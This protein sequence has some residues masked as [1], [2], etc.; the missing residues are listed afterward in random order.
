MVVNPS[1]SSLHVNIAA[2][3]WISRRSCRRFWV[4][5]VLLWDARCFWSVE[6]SSL[7]SEAVPCPPLS[8]GER[9]KQHNYNYDFPHSLYSSSTTSTETEEEQE[10]DIS[11]FDIDESHDSDWIENE[12]SLDSKSLWSSASDDHDDSVHLELLS[13][14]NGVEERIV[15]ALEPL[16]DEDE[17]DDD[18]TT[19]ND[20]WNSS[21]WPGVGSCPEDQLQ[22]T[23]ASSLESNEE[24][25]LEEGYDG[26]AIYS[27]R[28][29]LGK[30]SKRTPTSKKPTRKAAST[31]PD[32]PPRR[33]SNA[34]HRTP[35]H[36]GLPTKRAIAQERLLMSEQTGDRT[37]RN[38]KRHGKEAS[39][40]KEG[41]D[42]LLKNE[43]NQMSYQSSAI[44]NRDS[45]AL[46]DDHQR[47][48]VLSIELVNIPE[49]YLY[50]R[51]PLPRRRAP[52]NAQRQKLGR[53]RK[54]TAT[55][56][57]SQSLEAPE[58]HSDSNG[59]PPNKPA[60]NYPQSFPRHQ[61]QTMHAAT[62]TA[63]KPQEQYNHDILYKRSGVSAGSHS[64]IT[65]PTAVAGPW[66]R[67][68]LSCPAAKEERLMLVPLDFWMDPFNLAHL[69]PVVERIVHNYGPHRHSST[70]TE[71]NTMQQSTLSET[72]IHGNRPSSRRSQDE[73]I[74][75][76]QQQQH[77]SSFP[78]YR[79]A[80]QL[81][82]SQETNEPR[83]S[84]KLQVDADAEFENTLVEMAAVVLY[85]LVHQRYVVSPRG[86]E[87]LRRR[88]LFISTHD[89]DNGKQSNGGGMFQTNAEPVNI[90]FGRCP[91]PRC[92]GMPL[93]PA[94]LDDY[95]VADWSCQN[96]RHS[97]RYCAQCHKYWV[98]YWGNSTSTV[99]TTTSPN[100]MLQLDQCVQDCAWGL[101]LGPLFHLTF[102]GFLQ[103]T[104]GAQSESTPTKKRPPVPPEE[105]RIFGFRLHPSAIYRPESTQD[106]CIE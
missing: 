35:R 55:T 45:T 66:V 84:E 16:D 18:A 19:Y 87:A 27:T 31:L 85:C 23:E 83:L 6:P 14:D 65:A 73:T 50:K 71:T 12:N 74:L 93:L 97:L 33:H 82:T 48:P 44:G 38:V 69:A 11:S 1:K 2:Q 94:G 21:L 86:L 78:L 95:F 13:S 29:R 92:Y 39:D 8:N 90:L 25:E 103:P 30:G 20:L 40:K 53:S 72:V 9:R 59:S 57:E 32:P 105:P 67:K 64:A 88:F 10:Q 37:S 101:S 17:D 77:A 91:R 96:P 81:I 52:S 5:L 75:R 79:R 102:P 46:S 61:D 4:F 58:K 24:E 98:H 80:L 42:Q 68:L 26:N 60:L 28:F 43:D 22:H 104:T 70:S 62:V 89:D 41:Y 106:N 56:V 47:S 99:T 51:H 54:P 34:L 76:S 15:A 7:S 36:R 100:K 3:S 49:E 63:T